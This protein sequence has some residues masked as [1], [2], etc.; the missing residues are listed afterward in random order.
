LSGRGLAAG[1]EV[2]PDLI[3]E[4]GDQLGCDAEP[5]DG[6]SFESESVGVTVSNGLACLFDNNVI[7]GEKF[8]ECTGNEAFQWS[9]PFRI[10]GL[11]SRVS[12]VKSTSC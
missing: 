6:V 11:D 10:L 12:F 2:G 7:C 1:F 3:G 9:E 4:F 8:G 5:A